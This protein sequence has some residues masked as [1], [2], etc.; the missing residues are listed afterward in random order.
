MKNGI[1]E[2]LSAVAKKRKKVD[3]SALLIETVRTTPQ[4]MTILKYIFKDSIL[5]S[6]PEGD[7][8]YKP[9]AKETDLQNVLYSEFRR[10]KI[11]MKGEYPQ[12]RPIKRETLFVEFLE[13][14]DPDDAKLLIAMKDKKSPYKGLTKKFV[15]DTF[16][17]DTKGW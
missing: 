17:K 2:L 10:I 13:S 4:V 12:M 14:L 16:P 1:A 5:W 6:L 7:P 3:K 9:Q 11:F 15:C 8:P